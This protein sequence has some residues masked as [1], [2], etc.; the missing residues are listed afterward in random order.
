M[1]FMDVVGEVL[2]R[3]HSSWKF[4]FSTRLLLIL[5]IKKLVDIVMLNLSLVLAFC[6][7]GLVAPTCTYY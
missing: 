4:E 2:I 1:V 3:L 6:R 5:V 7:V